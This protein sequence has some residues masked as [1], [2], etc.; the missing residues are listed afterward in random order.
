MYNIMY[1][2]ENEEIRSPKEKLNKTD[3]YQ[4]IQVFIFKNACYIFGF[5][6]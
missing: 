3:D 6:L 1:R 4:L 5:K 2:R